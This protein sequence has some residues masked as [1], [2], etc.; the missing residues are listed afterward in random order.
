MNIEHIESEIDSLNQES[1]NVL[2]DRQRDINRQIF[3]LN[4]FSN[5]IKKAETLMTELE[6]E[7]C[8]LQFT[9]NLDVDSVMARTAYMI[10]IRAVCYEYGIH[11]TDSKDGYSFTVPASL[12]LNNVELDTKMIEERVARQVRFR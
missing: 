8:M 11:V 5:L 9:M 10:I 12:I 4:F 3:I 7:G 2:N 1:L 6:S